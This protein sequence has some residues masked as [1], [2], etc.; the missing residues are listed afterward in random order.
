MP[1][2]QMR[3]IED[4]LNKNKNTNY[5]IY[6]WQFNAILV[7][8]TKYKNDDVV[9]E[10]SKWVTFS[11]RMTNTEIANEIRRTFKR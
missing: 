8:K 7:N 5:N 10:E 9:N 3:A 6:S 2:S 11:S 4:M 1:N